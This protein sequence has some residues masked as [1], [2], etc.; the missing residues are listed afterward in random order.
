MVFIWLDIFLWHVLN[1]HNCKLTMVHYFIS[2]RNESKSCIENGQDQRF[3][4]ALESKGYFLYKIIFDCPSYVWQIKVNGRFTIF[5]SCINMYLLH[6]TIPLYLCKLRSGEV[7]LSL[8]RFIV[9]N[10]T[11]IW[12]KKIFYM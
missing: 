8:D 10:N 1:I 4:T 7:R 2:I 6:L 5:F 9:N 11:E 12:L 3:D